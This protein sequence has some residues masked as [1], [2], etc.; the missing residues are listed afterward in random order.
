MQCAKCGIH[1]DFSVDGVL[2]F[3]IKAGVTKGSV[4][5]VNKKAFTIDAQFGIQ[6]ELQAE[7]SIDLVKKQLGSLPLSPLTI[8]G[9]ILLGPEVTV[10][11]ELELTLNG[12]ANLLIGGSLSVSEGRAVMDAVNST[13]NELTGLKAEFTPVAK[14]NGTI[15][16]S[17]QLGLPIALEVGL[18]ILNGKW[19]KSVGL[20]EKPSDASAT[21]AKN[22]D[23]ACSNGVEI[24][25]G[26]KNQLYLS[27][28]DY[29][30][31]PIRNDII[32]ERGLV[33]I[34]SKGFNFQDVG[35]GTAFNQA[36]A[37]SPGRKDQIA[38][39][40]PEFRNV[41][42][43][44]TPKVGN[45]GYRVIVD[46]GQTSIVVAGKDGGVYLVASDERYDLSAPWGTL[47]LNSNLV[48]LDVFGRIMS[49][50]LF[51][52]FLGLADVQLVDPKFVP[53]DNK[54]ASLNMVKEDSSEEYQGYAIVVGEQEKKQD[55]GHLVVRY[56]TFCRTPSGTRL[57]ATQ[58]IMNDK[59]Q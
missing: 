57:F 8:P 14:L 12:L 45:T 37:G 33:C 30:E 18:D 24:R 16:A 15:T 34:S 52:A 59:G 19:K 48:N 32:Y 35:A 20:V 25:V 10:S 41:S 28:L 5:L 4:S 2:A 55:K 3:S 38:D 56:P 39:S 11:A 9:I 53:E 7:K 29:Y 51:F 42:Q 31:V 44:L 49:V 46:H 6:V 58:W 21:V 36:I 26:V 13:R 17:M 47:D 43:S 23:K 40:Q 27:V 50:N 54:V 22:V 1:A